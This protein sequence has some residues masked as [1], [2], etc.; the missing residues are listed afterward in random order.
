VSFDEQLYGS[1]SVAGMMARR[2]IIGANRRAQT[3]GWT[4]GKYRSEDGELREMDELRRRLW[5]TRTTPN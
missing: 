4:F 2:S 5:E 1:L 3:N